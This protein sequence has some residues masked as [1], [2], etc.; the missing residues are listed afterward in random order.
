MLSIIN[1]SIIGTSQYKC[2]LLLMVTA[3]C[4]IW[5]DIGVSVWLLS[6]RNSWLLLG[7]GL[8]FRLA[9]HIQPRRHDWGPGIYRGEWCYISQP[10]YQTERP[11]WQ[12]GCQVQDTGQSC[13]SAP[14]SWRGGLIWKSLCQSSPGEW[15]DAADK[16]AGQ[17]KEKQLRI[18][19]KCTRRSIFEDVIVE[20]LVVNLRLNWP[21]FWSKLMSRRVFVCPIHSPLMCLQRMGDLSRLGWIGTDVPR[22]VWDLCY[23]C[24]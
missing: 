14:A 2:F 8:L 11:G 4:L 6:N 12:S 16:I 21:Q 5:M 18:F 13:Q 23:S 1:A 17:W 15:R 19:E 9:N 22:Q 20:R 24:E 7:V 10:H 3:R